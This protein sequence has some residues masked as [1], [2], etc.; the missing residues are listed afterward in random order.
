MTGI[1]TLPR[2]SSG[3]RIKEVTSTQFNTFILYYIYAT[4]LAVVGFFLFDISKVWSVV[5]AMHNLLEVALLVGLHSGG[6]T[7]NVRFALY[8]FTYVFLVV[9]ASIYLPWPVDAVFFRWQGLCS[10]YGLIIMFS[11]MYST[12]KAQLEISGGA[13]VH[14][15]RIAIV[16]SGI[17]CSNNIASIYSIQ[18]QS[19][20]DLDTHAHS[21]NAANNNTVDAINNELDLENPV[22]SSKW[23]NPRQLLFLIVAAIVHTFGNDFATIFSTQPYAN[24]V[25][26]ASY[27]ITFPLYAYYLYVDTHALRQ[28]KIYM[29]Q[30]AALK[31]F[32]VTC[33][34]IALATF[35]VRLG[36]L[37]IQLSS[38]PQ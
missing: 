22:W 30:F 35:T 6:Q 26:L 9:V 3:E 18:N 37:Y 13:D 21:N 8:L 33:Y 28:S 24:G 17:A 4:W 1:V 36:F 25:F 11:R 7:T 15:Q 20:G 12:T 10:D 14:D 16:Q 31:N 2:L 34:C 32:T 19:N 38:P 29:P 27:G 5:G 23:E